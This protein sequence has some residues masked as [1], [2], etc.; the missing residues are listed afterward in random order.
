MEIKTIFLS[1]ETATPDESL[2]AI[3][4][5]VYLHKPK[6]AKSYTVGNYSYSKDG[7]YTREVTGNVEFEVN[8][9]T[10]IKEG[11]HP[12]IEKQ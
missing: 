12:I 5:K 11:E 7:F 3:I 4:G 10:T 2:Y 1:V 9:F 8:Y 6:G